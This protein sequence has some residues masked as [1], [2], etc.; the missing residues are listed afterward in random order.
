MASHN[1]RGRTPALKIGS[2]NVNS[3]IKHSTAAHRL[4][5][6]SGYQVVLVQETRAHTESP[7][8]QENFE[9]LVEE[10]EW[11]GWC[12]YW[13]NSNR[14]HAGVAICIDA[15][16]IESGNLQV[17][18]S[19]T[20]GVMGRAL[21]L[22]IK[23]GGHCFNLLNVYFPQ[24]ND[25]HDPGGQGKFVRCELAA[26][27]DENYDTLV[28]GDFNFVHNK[29]RDRLPHPEI[30]ASDPREEGAKCWEETLP[31]LKDTYRILH[32]T[33]NEMSFFHYNGGNASRI[34]RFYA[35]SA[36]MSY[37]CS[38]NISRSP[39]PSD[40][41]PVSIS[42]L[43]TTGAWIGT[44]RKRARTDFLSYPDLKEAFCQLINE[45]VI[46]PPD[47][48]LLAWWPAIP[49]LL[50][51]ASQDLHKQVVIRRNNAQR[52]EAEEH[53]DNVRAAAVASSNSEAA[54]AALQ[55]LV[56]ARK[57]WQEIWRIECEDALRV[58]RRQELYAGERITAAAAKST[59]LPLS[60]VSIPALSN[61]HGQLV[62][63]RNAANV[64]AKHYA[65]V[66]KQPATSEAAQHQ[67]LSALDDHLTLDLPTANSL[68]NVTITEAEVLEAFSKMQAGKS[69]GIDGVPIELYRCCADLFVPLFAR[70]FSVIASSQET[71]MGFLDG[72][73]ALLYKT[74]NRHDV[75]SYRPITLLNTA[76]RLFAKVLANR[77]NPCLAKVIDLEQTAYIRNRTIGDA[78]MLLQTVPQ[79]LQQLR[80]RGFIVFCDFAKAYDTVDRSFLFKVMSKLGLGDS[81]INIIKTLLPAIT[82]SSAKINNFLSVAT[83]F[84]AGVRQGCPISPLLYLC[85]AQALLS[86]LKSKGLGIMLDG[87][88]IVA[89]QFADD[90]EGFFEKATD[91]ELFVNSM[92]T[93]AEASGQHLNMQKTKVMPIGDWSTPTEA[94]PPTIAGLSVVQ[95]ATSLGVTL[96]AYTGF[97]IPDWDSRIQQVER[98]YTK[99]AKWHLSIFGRARNS[100]VYGVSKLL[101]HAQYSGWPGDTVIK[102]LDHMTAKLVDRGI[103]PSKPD[104]HFK[105]NAT[106]LIGAPKQGGFGAFPWK[107]HI[108]ARHACI[109]LKVMYGDDNIK[110]VKVARSILHAAKFPVLAP[111]WEESHSTISP[112]ITPQYW[113]VNAKL[114]GHLKTCLAAVQQL[115]PPMQIEA[116]TSPPPGPWCATAPLWG[117]LPQHRV[118]DN[119]EWQVLEQIAHPEIWNHP[120]LQGPVIMTVGELCEYYAQLQMKAAVAQ[121]QADYEAVHTLAE[122][123]HR[124]AKLYDAIPLEWTEAACTVLNAEQYDAAKQSMPLNIM[125]SSYGW[126]LHS[127]AFAVNDI[128]VKAATE[129]LL[130]Q[131]QIT[132]KRKSSLQ[133][134]ALAAGKRDEVGVGQSQAVVAML[135][136]L[137]KLPLPP[138]RK[139]TVW[140]LIHNGLPT[141]ERMGNGARLGDRAYCACCGQHNPGRQHHFWDCSVLS[142]LKHQLTTAV[143]APVTQTNLWLAES[144]TTN[145]HGRVWSVV[146][147]AAVH[148]M[149]VGKLCAYNM[150][151]KSS[152]SRQH[153]F[154]HVSRLTTVQFWEFLTEFCSY[155]DPNKSRWHIDLPDNHPFLRCG[156]DNT[157]FCAPLNHS[158]LLNIV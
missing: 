101:H 85:I 64:A 152:H 5:R 122:F 2:H 3:L 19:G 120:E 68:G 148:A 53:L 158:Q 57:K 33:R 90:T 110:W 145:V 83:P 1:R 84:Y 138:K 78:I 46:I 82:Y 6:Q 141:S 125:L 115:P 4:W 130:Q 50:L 41:H 137:C 75:S 119:G 8:A 66:S 31:W 153:T 9:A 32:P 12:T 74:G 155:Y 44:D 129:L 22:R 55:E 63:G 36:L 37:V 11:H 112:P 47:S 94:L 42:L 59:N 99:I 81:F 102:Q 73:V 40:H 56:T 136:R 58:I 98:S 48:Q 30:S 62:T 65:S 131:Q 7:T 108:Q 121:L 116:L 20:V 97:P 142:E 95:Q 127:T 43:A 144:P 88:I 106:Y 105:L 72:L 149:N 79:R 96:S 45:Q 124:V 54:A 156:A 87:E 61:Q 52:Q 67:V 128:T 133:A 123:I 25:P 27:L 14:G 69:P 17:L 139:E 104:S 71:P 89:S 26:M 51:K 103:A 23:W 135:K 18:N 49:R 34:D 93:F 15:G 10:L 28:G 91:I 146:C 24:A 16:L 126:R 35:S 151:Y 80:R 154:Q 111:L 70:L 29:F 92:Q 117:C 38:S 157:L 76:Y 60:A 86:F 77:L 109:G 113:D 100:G 39:G 118:V 140:R 150:V 107:Q 13:C 132:S 21:K 134:Y 114:D 147:V 143:A